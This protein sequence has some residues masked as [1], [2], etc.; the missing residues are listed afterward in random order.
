MNGSSVPLV[1][2]LFL[3]RARR[4]HTMTQHNTPF[5]FIQ[6]SWSHPCRRRC[7]RS[8][9][10]QCRVASPKMALPLEESL[11]VRRPDL[12]VHQLAGQPIVPV[13][14]P[15]V[16]AAIPWKDHDAMD[17][18]L[19]LFLSHGGRLNVIVTLRLSVKAMDMGNSNSNFVF[20]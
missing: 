12:L 9:L 16:R 8:S 5:A 2:E 11:W 3:S 15:D 4:T 17:D 14:V 20:N 18:L 10:D 6:D 19:G 13:A 7:P 1:A